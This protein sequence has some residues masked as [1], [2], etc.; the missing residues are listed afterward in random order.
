[1]PTAGRQLTPVLAVLIG[2][3]ALV[4]LAHTG[5]SLP[6]ARGQTA[7][8]P[9]TPAR[10]IVA[11]SLNG[12]VAVPSSAS[13]SEAIAGLQAAAQATASSTPAGSPEAGG[14]VASTSTPPA[15]PTLV[16]LTP[17]NQILSPAAA[18]SSG[19]GVAQ[20]TS[21]QALLNLTRTDGVTLIAGRS[22]VFVPA[23]AA[24]CDAAAQLRYTPDESVFA[25]ECS[26]GGLQF[27]QPATL[28]MQPSAQLLALARGNLA[29]LAI[30][31][32]G[33]LPS[34]VSP[35][36]VLV[37]SAISAP[38]T[39]DLIVTGSALPPAALHAVPKG[40]NIHLPAVGLGGRSPI[41]DG[42]ELK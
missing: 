30:S 40:V 36:G 3:L 8:P 37:C 2:T 17:P 14:D 16:A 20:S 9:P 22:L 32:G 6:A 18:S 1:M 7:G 23:Q 26:G 38:G 24:S 15:T 4:L 12:G 42:P 21:S 39:Y 31:L 35:S 33:H 19:Q 28:C 34:R 25:A 41:R 10:P 27:S 13:E 29:N 11:G 5:G